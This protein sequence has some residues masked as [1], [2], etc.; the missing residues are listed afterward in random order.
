MEMI[1]HL[2]DVLGSFMSGTAFAALAM[3]VEMFL[4]MTKS[5]KPI[6]II[7]GISGFLKAV[8]GLFGKVAEML[9]KVLPQKL[10]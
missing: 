9:D 1:K 3:V 8:G 7:H 10:N 6:G 4:R 2:M 5:D